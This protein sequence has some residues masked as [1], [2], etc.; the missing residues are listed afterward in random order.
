MDPSE[1]GRRLFP[2]SANGLDGGGSPGGMGQERPHTLEE[3]AVDHFRWGQ[4][5]GFF[6]LWIYSA[7]LLRFFLD[8]FELKTKVFLEWRWIICGSFL[9]KKHKYEHACLEFLFICQN[10][11]GPPLSAPWARAWPSPR[12]GRGGRRRTSGGTGGTQSGETITIFHFFV[13]SWIE[14]VSN[15]DNRSWRSWPTRTS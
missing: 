14:Y 1:H 10:D 13:G 11:S 5:E 9:K 8:D 2:A 4:I 6:L 3:Y 12:P 15:S 7:F